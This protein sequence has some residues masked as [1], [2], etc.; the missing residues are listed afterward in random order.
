VGST[1]TLGTNLFNNYAALGDKDKAFVQLD[2][3]YAG[4]QLLWIK[5]E[6][7]YDPLRDDPRFQELV[8]KVGF[9]Q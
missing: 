4:W 5:V 2:R 1:P 6:P 3:A 9:P 8:R 7:L